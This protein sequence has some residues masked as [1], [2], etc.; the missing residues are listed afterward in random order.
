MLQTGTLLDTLSGKESVSSALRNVPHQDRADLV[1]QHA[2]ELAAVLPTLWITEQYPPTVILHGTADSLV[3]LEESR[4]IT[5]QLRTVG[6][7]VTLHEVEGGVHGFDTPEGWRGGPGGQ[8]AELTR[9][10][11]EVLR[12]VLPWLLARI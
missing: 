2:P 6:V 9:K 8:D 1:R 4:A 3:K 11:D 7:D 12:S 10:K 5:K